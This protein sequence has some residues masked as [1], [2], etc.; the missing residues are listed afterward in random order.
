VQCGVV[1]GVMGDAES[2][3]SQSLAMILW[4]FASAGAASGQ[5]LF[6][7]IRPRMASFPLSTTRPD[8]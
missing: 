2:D 6:F 8:L 7:H 5:Q 3:K 1:G 4:P